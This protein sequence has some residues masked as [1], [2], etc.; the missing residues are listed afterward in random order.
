VLTSPG[1]PSY[2]RR[3]AAVVGY[4]QGWSSERVPLHSNGH[5]RH[6]A[7]TGSMALPYSNG[8][9]L[10]SKW[11]DAERWIF[12]PNPHDAIGRN[13]LPQRRR[14]KSKS[15][16]LGPPGRFGAPYSSLTSFLDSSGVGNQ[17]AHSPF[18]PGVLLADHVSGGSSNSGDDIRGASGEDSSNGRG[19]RSGP[20]NG[21]HP[22]VWSMRDHHLLNS[23]LRSQSLLT[24]QEYTQGI[25]A[26][27]S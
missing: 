25:D 13:S 16:P 20:V 6:P 10:P 8:R 24:S 2:S 27:F 12:S 22:S 23:S 7:G 3:G 5:L 4:Q 26:L 15:G 17:A 11:E 18:L 19:G 21:G 1:T 9:V 14:P